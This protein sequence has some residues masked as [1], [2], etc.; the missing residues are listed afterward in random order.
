[1]DFFAL[2]ICLTVAGA[3]LFHPD[4]EANPTSGWVQICMMACGG[5]L[6]LCYAVFR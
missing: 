4:W 2:A 1:M 5:L 3:S 6:S